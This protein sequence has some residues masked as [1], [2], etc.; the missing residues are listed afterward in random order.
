MSYDVAALVISTISAL[1]AALSLVISFRRR[2]FIVVSGRRS[3]S[4]KKK[5]KRYVLFKV[6]CFQQCAPQNIIDAANKAVREALGEILKRYCSFNVVTVA[7][8][9]EKSG[10]LIARIKGAQLCVDAL[11]YALSKQHIS[12][13]TSIVMIPVKTSGLLKKLVKLTAMRASTV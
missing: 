11:T 2:P 8:S 1:I 10:Y 9:T 12:S 3:I 4:A 13:Q 7:M 5:L 6:L